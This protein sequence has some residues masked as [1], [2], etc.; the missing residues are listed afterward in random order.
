MS[1]KGKTRFDTGALRELAGGKVFARGEAY[2][3][4]GQVQILAIKP[5]RVLAQVAGTEDYRTELRGHGRDIDGECS[6]RAFEDH[7]FCK[8][9]VATALAANDSGADEVDG[10]GALA[11]IR[12]HLKEKGVDALVDIVVG[13]VEHDPALFRKLDVVAA[14]PHEDEKTLGKRLRK[15]IDSVTRTRDFV[16]YREAEGWA[17]EVDS[18]LDIISGLASGARAGLAC[19]L[20]VH[21]IDRVGQAAGSIDDSDGHCGA[22]LGRARDIHCIAVCE[23]RPEP[24]ELARDLFAR[25]MSDDYGTFDS[26]AAIYADALGVTGLAEYRR[27]AG[28]AWEKTARP[29][30]RKAPQDD[31][32]IDRHQ[33]MRILDF[34][35]ERDGDVDARIALRAKELSSQLDYHQLAQF[36]LSHGR[37]DEALRRAEEGLWMFEDGQPDVRLVMLAADLLAK[38]GRKADAEAHLWRL[39][40]K[41]PSL[42]LYAR[43]CGLGGEAARSRAMSFLE[44]KLSSGKRIGW[45]SPADLLIRIWMQEK[46]FDAAWTAV[47]KHGASMDLE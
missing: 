41:H 29:A 35:A 10:G 45:L 38:A 14:A 12:D 22:L 7:G 33:L 8:H 18:V 5:E 19:E 36:C 24:I 15:A 37:A 39:F 11:R 21:A 28:E 17:A 6:C 9:M 30:R 26:A 16:D 1:A 32:T 27:L 2:H 42:D 3:R 43:L 34:F 4:D 23:V 25:E 46:M 13:L 44:D 47:R 20:A 31:D 40:Q